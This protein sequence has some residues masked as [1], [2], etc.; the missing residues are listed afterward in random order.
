MEFKLKKNKIVATIEAR[1]NSARL[2]GKVLKKIGKFPSL[3]LQVKRIRK[4]NFVDE[5]VIATTN[6]S[7]DDSIENFCKKINCKVFRGSENDVMER[8]LHAA[9][10]E[11]ADIQVQITGDCPLI[12]SEIIDDLI[13]F[14][15]ANK[16]LDFVSNE[17]ERSFPVGLDCRVFK[18]SALE[19]ANQLCRDSIHR[20]HGSTFIYI[21]EGKKIFKSKNIL[22]PKKLNLPNLR[23]T[24]DTKE[25]L[26]FFR[27]L[28]KH[29]NGDLSD[30]NS[31]DIIEWLELN[32]KVSK[33]NQHI[34]QKAFEEG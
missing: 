33:I 23:W 20:V 7:V 6:K 21:G 13:K 4:S 18:V 12:D 1:M 17:I 3:E 31:I 24:L 8:I 11:S 28:A 30:L 25:D 5:I 22:A 29:F 19:K 14:I 16:D 34:K 27:T 9:K 32:P 15:L 26:N 2:P 10:S